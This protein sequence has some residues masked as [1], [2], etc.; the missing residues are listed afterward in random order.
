[1]TQITQCP[2][3]QT[4]F[5]VDAQQLAIADGKVRCGAC[6]SVFCAPDYFITQ[7]T[8]PKASVVK[9]DEQAMS[10][11]EHDYL[12]EL[13]D[14]DLADEE[15]AGDDELVDEPLVEEQETFTPAVDTELSQSTNME[16][17]AQQPPEQSQVVSAKEPVAEEN[18]VNQP[19]ESTDMEEQIVAQEQAEQVSTP[20]EPVAEAAQDANLEAQTQTAEAKQND[21]AIPTPSSLEAEDFTQADSTPVASEQDDD[22]QSY[23]PLAGMD[24]VKVA[25]SSFSSEEEQAQQ[26]LNHKRWQEEEMQ[27][28]SPVDDVYSLIKS[29]LREQK[30]R[31][32]PDAFSGELNSKE[33]NIEDPA[34]TPLADT[35]EQSLYHEPE[36]Q[37]PTHSTQRSAQQTQSHTGFWLFVVLLLM[38]GALAQVA[39]FKFDTFARHPDTRF[40]YQQACTL[41]GC[42]LPS[43]QD[44]KK[45]VVQQFLI[46][47]QK[48]DKGYLQADILLINKAIYAQPYPDLTLVMRDNQ[49]QVLAS[50]RF[51]P[52]EFLSYRAS[53]SDGLMPSGV[54][55]RARLIV[56]APQG[57]RASEFV[58]VMQ[59]Q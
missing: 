47:P 41:L 57:Q 44:S 49:G 43:V 52:K 9:A 1:M 35:Q 6:M 19:L 2:H 8:M 48:Q 18:S 31:I 14:D 23:A 36:T 53:L 21:D 10:E 12:A 56:K 5:T 25:Q 11:L 20:K 34:P 17:D 22:E 38:L 55:V 58:H 46:R 29:D 15:Q 39:Y 40:V 59:N 3:C 16:F 42:E 7:E 28:G 13:E 37:A 32:E 33:Q 50:R 4:A 30:E 27:A 54:P 24:N 51:V 26:G 45:I